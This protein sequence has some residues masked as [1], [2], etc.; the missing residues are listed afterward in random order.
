MARGLAEDGDIGP[1]DLRRIQVLYDDARADVNA[2]LDRLLVE[3]EVTGSYES[4]DPFADV[5]ER[6]ESRVAS[7]ISETDEIIFGEDRSLGAAGIGL[8]GDIAQAF[9][10]VWKTFRG[11]S[12]ANHDKLVERIDALKWAR[13]EDL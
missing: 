6:A 5:A 11:E 2:G 4:A 13:Y 3:L 8:V 10:E 1:T 12:V 9:V 7:F